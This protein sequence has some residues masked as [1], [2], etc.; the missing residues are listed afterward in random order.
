MKATTQLKVFSTVLA[1]FFSCLLLAQTKYDGD[2]LTSYIGRT[3]ESPE[4]KGFLNNYHCD[5]AN[6]NHCIAGEGLELDFKNGTLSEI[7]IY[8]TSAVYGSFIGNLPKALKFGMS[9]EEVTGIL[10]K[11]LISFSKGYTLYSQNDYEVSCWFEAGKL[12]QMKIADK[13]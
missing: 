5:I 6:P 4:M 13:R 10:G 7:T 2:I 3:A 9:A 8:Q 1:V 12:I 11:P